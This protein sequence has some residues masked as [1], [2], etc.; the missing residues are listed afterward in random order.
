M[1]PVPSCCLTCCLT[2]EDLRNMFREELE[3]AKSDWAKYF[4]RNAVKEIV[5]EMQSMENASKK[6]EHGDAIVM[7][8][9]ANWN[10]VREFNGE[11]FSDSMQKNSSSSYS[12]SVLGGQTENRNHVQRYLAPP[13][14][15]APVGPE[16]PLA[17]AGSAAEG[18]CQR[19]QNCLSL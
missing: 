7:K 9:L 1:N 18:T 15:A 16:A 3:R 19:T 2:K 10:D 8:A 17:N 12:S 11:T 13:I 6:L 5:Q 4:Q 14:V